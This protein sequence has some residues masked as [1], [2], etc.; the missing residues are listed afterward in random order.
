MEIRAQGYFYLSK[1]KLME[2]KDEAEIK[3][4]R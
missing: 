1:C 2:A 4:T 3:T